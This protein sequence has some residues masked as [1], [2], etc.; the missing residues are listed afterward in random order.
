MVAPMLIVMEVL[1]NLIS[2]GNFDSVSVELEAD[3]FVTIIHRALDFTHHR[4]ISLD[5]L[6]P[7]LPDREAELMAWVM[8]INLYAE[9][10]LTQ[11]AFNASANAV[12]H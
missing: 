1:E 3:N 11:Q 7:Y 12:L 4:S 9:A 8:E 10:A 5:S 6:S 2:N